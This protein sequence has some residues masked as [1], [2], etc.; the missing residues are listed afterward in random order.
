MIQS[1]STPNDKHSLCIALVDCLKRMWG[2]TDA[3]L[4]IQ[5]VA[6]RSLSFKRGLGVNQARARLK[7]AEGSVIQY[8]R[9]NN[10][11]ESKENVGTS[12]GK[13]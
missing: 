8:N 9:S 4:W 2:L 10:S 12:K 11:V 1:M 5:L 6:E 3:F 7:N 13:R